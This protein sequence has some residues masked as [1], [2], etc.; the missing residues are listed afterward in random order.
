MGLANTRIQHAVGQGFFHA[1]ELHEGSTLVS[2]F[3]PCQ[4]LFIVPGGPDSPGAPELERSGP[5]G[6]TATTC[7][8]C[9][10]KRVR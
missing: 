6:L 4:I 1:A 2:G 7:K 10:T 9:V 3:G 8:V 5:K